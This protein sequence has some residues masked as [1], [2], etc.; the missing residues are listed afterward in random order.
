MKGNQGGS[1]R[2]NEGESGKRLGEGSAIG[3]HL[4]V[5]VRKLIFILR[6]AGAMGD[7]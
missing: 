1:G 4:H 7:G 5:R 6:A 2:V 3:Q